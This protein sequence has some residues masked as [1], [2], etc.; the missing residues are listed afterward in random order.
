MLDAGTAYA[1]NISHASDGRAL[2]WLWG[3]T[4]TEPQRGWNGRMTLVRELTVDADGFL[5]QRPAVEYEAL[6]GQPITHSPADLGATPLVLPLRG[7]TL[8]LQADI[9]L[10]KA[11]IIGLRARTGAGAA[12]SIE[13]RYE[14]GCRLHLGPASTLLGVRDRVRLRLFVDRSVAELYADDGAAAIFQ[15]FHCT[16]GANG[17]EVFAQ[18]GAARLESATAWPLRAARFSL[19]RFSV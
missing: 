7:D 8:E 16:P 15:C 3:R 10:G 1:S 11:N 4:E 12:R 5:R 2:L 19:D 17:V 9:T 13:A 14:R 6:R 18:G